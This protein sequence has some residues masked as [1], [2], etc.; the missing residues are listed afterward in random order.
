MVRL[1]VAFRRN[2]RNRQT[3]YHLLFRSLSNVGWTLCTLLHR[4]G[5]SICLS[6]LNVDV[7]EHLDRLDFLLKK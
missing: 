1:M 6:Y 2:L 4:L 7:I 3:T 5:T